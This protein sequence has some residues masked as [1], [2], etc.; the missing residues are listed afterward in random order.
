MTVLLL[1]KW[2][3]MYLY[4]RVLKCFFFF[5]FKTGLMMNIFKRLEK[6][7]NDIINSRQWLKEKV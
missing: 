5:H 2:S 6:L 4:Y 7:K 3:S 1:D